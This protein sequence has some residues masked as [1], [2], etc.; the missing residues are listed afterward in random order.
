M[1]LIL[2]SKRLVCGL[3][4]SPDSYI[5]VCLSISFSTPNLALEIDPIFL[6]SALVHD[7]LCENHRYVDYDRNF[8]TEVF[9]ALLESSQVPALKRFF[10]TKSVNF[11]QFFCYFYIF[12]FYFS[13]NVQSATAKAT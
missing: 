3:N 4:V 7:V 12:A 9:N 10:M 2:S 13:A 6:I 1:S 8:S 5:L 11:Y